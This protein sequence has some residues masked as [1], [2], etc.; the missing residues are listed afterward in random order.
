MF[1][2]EKLKLKMKTKTDLKYLALKT[3]NDQRLESSE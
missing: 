1:A 3:Q 2:V